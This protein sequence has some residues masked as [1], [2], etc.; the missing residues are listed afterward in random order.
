MAE[1]TTHPAPGGSAITRNVPLATVGL[2]LGMLLSAL[3]QTVVAIALPDIAADLGGLD[4]IGWVITSYLLGSAATAVFY[5]R[6]SDRFG[7]RAVFITAIAIFIVASALSGAAQS[8]VQLIAA[9]SLQGIGAGALF[10][11]PTIALSE[12][13]PQHLRSRIQGATGAVFAVATVLGPLAGGAIT[14]LVGWRWIFYINLPLGLLS[15]V[16]VALALRVPTPAS[17]ER[18]D[19]AGAGLIVAATVSA[20]LVAEWGG[21]TYAWGSGPIIGLAGIA[22]LLLALFVWWER[23]AAAPLLPLALFTNPTLRIT[24]PATAVL[25]ALLGGSIVYLP[26]YLQTAYGMGAT[27]AGLA[28][29]PYVLTFMAVSFLAGPRLG[30]SGRFRRYLV[31]GALV[32]TLAFALLGLLDPSMSYVVVALVLVV[33]G[34]GFGLLMQNLVVIAQNA[35]SA[36]DLAAASSA[37]VY[38]RGLGLA[39]GAAVFGSLL[40]RQLEGGEGGPE[41]TALAIPQVLAWGIPLAVV[42]VVLM[43]ALPRTVDQRETEATDNSGEAPRPDG[44][45]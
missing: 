30:T 31:S 4:G 35:S 7:R 44:S 38:V 22:L 39:L 6:L 27:V 13:Y 25:G 2:L 23:R 12:I 32:V 41:A 15:M 21:R 26:T 17:K 14:D 18:I 24:L 36:K 11:L 10:V 34:A 8:M 42:L 5:G 19:F 16:L 1:T 43:A 33:M 9:R 28:L 3:D 20:L 45:A 37:V 40:V 29:N